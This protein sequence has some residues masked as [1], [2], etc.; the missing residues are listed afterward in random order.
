MFNL[1]WQMACAGLVC[2]AGFWNV[3]EAAGQSLGT[4]STNPGATSGMPISGIPIRPLPL[5]D[6][7]VCLTAAE[8]GQPGNG[9]GRQSRA[10]QHLRQSLCC[11]LDLRE[12][13]AGAIR[14]RSPSCVIEL[15]IHLDEPPT[16]RGCLSTT[17]SN[18]QADMGLGVMPDGLD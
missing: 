4:P 1:R 9:C 15:G 18:A 13:D 16:R 12:H 14:F 7:D 17:A 8:R 11:A 6:A 3:G 2:V 5:D 10:G